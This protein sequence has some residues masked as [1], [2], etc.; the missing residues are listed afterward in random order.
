MGAPMEG[1]EAVVNMVGD[2][3]ERSKATFEATRGHGVMHVAQA[4]ATAA[5]HDLSTSRASA[6]IETPTH[7]M[8]V[9]AALAS[10]WSKRFSRGH[11]SALASSSGPRAASSTDWRP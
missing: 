3:L 1:P 6:P 7:P 9:P 4:A 5:V 10:S 8:P 11:H 2:Y